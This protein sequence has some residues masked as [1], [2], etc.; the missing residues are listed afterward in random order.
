MGCKFPSEYFDRGLVAALYLYVFACGYCAF[1]DEY[2][3]I[4]VYRYVP[5]TTY[6]KIPLCVGICIIGNTG[7]YYQY[8]IPFLHCICWCLRGYFWYVRSVF[9]S[10][11]HKSYRE[12]RTE[13]LAEKHRCVHYTEPRKRGKRK[14]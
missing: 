11:Y 13:Y 2:V 6:R 14:H 1:A 10:A 8:D 12:E 5:G 7:E 9:F 4:A 3:C